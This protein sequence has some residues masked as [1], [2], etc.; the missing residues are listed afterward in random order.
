[1]LPCDARDFY[2][3]ANFIWWSAIAIEAVVLLRVA[4]TKLL[5]KYP[6]FFCYLTCI[7]ATEIVRLY[8]HSLTP[9]YYAPVYWCT[10]LLDA[11]AS[12]AIIVEIFRTALRNNPGV[13]RL[14][15]NMLLMIFVIAVSYAATDLSAGGFISLPRATA[16][17]GRDLRYVEGMLLLTM[18]WL[19]VRYRIRLGRSLTGITVGYA[20]WV[21]VNVM[22]M[23]FLSSAGHEAS[24]FIRQLLP[25]TYLLA[26][27]IWCVT[28]W[29][30]APE[31]MPVAT[32]EIENRYAIVA[33]RTRAIFASTSDRLIRVI[34]P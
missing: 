3:G 6:L 19:F 13:A 27:A 2:L 23:A 21:G 1:M 29:S 18:M 9:I 10:E 15:R 31:P 26:L 32:N 4:H 7:L 28:L 30:A 5:K 20:L 34:K 33:V 22:D 25:V 16:D 11:V 17:L 12:Y 8:V 24:M 14:A